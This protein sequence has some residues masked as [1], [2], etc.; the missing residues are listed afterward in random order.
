MYFVVNV[1][2][3]LSGDL[4]CDKDLLDDIDQTFEALRTKAPNNLFI[5]LH[6]EFAKYLE[7]KRAEALNFANILMTDGYPYELHNILEYYYLPFRTSRNPVADKKI[8]EGMF[9]LNEV[10]LDELIM[11]LICGIDPQRFDNNPEYL[12]RMNFFFNYDPITFESIG[13]SQRLGRVGYMPNNQNQIMLD[14][15]AYKQC[16][17]TPNALSIVG[18]YG[19]FMFVKYLESIKRPEEVIYWVSHD[20][21]DGFGYDVALYN[22]TINKLNLY[23]IKS[24]DDPSKFENIYLTEHETRVS[25]AIR[26]NPNE[27]YH[28]V[29]LC[30]EEP[31]QM[32]D[33]ND[34]SGDVMDIT[35]PERNRMIIKS[36]SGF[37][38]I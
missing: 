3:Y 28:I 31:F 7:V 20:L 17:S 8:F 2:K 12:Q 1:I 10:R 24:T 27:E 30:V 34:K 23:E 16:P 11:G 26:L 6:Q 32:V 5:K 4:Y 15:Q 37:K 25:N 22:P 18:N 9:R 36:N 38:L 13:N 35:Q 29:R 21:G 33:I 14:Y 19:E